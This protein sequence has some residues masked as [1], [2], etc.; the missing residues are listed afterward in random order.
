MTL[1]GISLIQKHPEGSPALGVHRGTLCPVTLLNL[2]PFPK[3]GA[4]IL[5]I[6]PAFHCAVRCIRGAPASL[7][8]IST[9]AVY[10]QDID[11]ER[12]QNGSAALTPFY[13]PWKIGSTGV[14]RHKKDRSCYK[15]V[16]SKLIGMYS[17]TRAPQL[18]RSM[19][20]DRQATRSK[21]CTLLG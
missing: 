11:L 8:P 15:E 5:S 17:G 16:G 21:H 7:S 14:D 18:W 12:D 10:Y 20:R 2:P 3:M 1:M 13:W 19:G 9:L 4:Q 6:F